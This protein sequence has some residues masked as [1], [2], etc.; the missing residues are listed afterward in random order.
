[1]L[2]DVDLHKKTTALES[3][4]VTHF[5]SS[6]TMTYKSIECWLKTE[7]RSADTSKGYKRIKEIIILKKMIL[8]Q[9]NLTS[10]SI[11]ETEYSTKAE[12][13][14]A[15]LKVLWSDD[16]WKAKTHKSPIK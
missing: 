15:K 2:S 3:T 1:M 16:E 13:A 7:R 4:N 10:E 11:S 9:Y 8:W 6:H 14:I 12:T 5:G